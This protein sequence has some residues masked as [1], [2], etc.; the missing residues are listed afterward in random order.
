MSRAVNPF[1]SQTSASAPLQWPLNKSSPPS[2]RSIM[3][4]CQTL[5]ILQVQPGPILKNEPENSFPA[6]VL[7]YLRSGLLCRH[8]WREFRCLVPWQV[9]PL[10]Q[11]R[12]LKLSAAVSCTPSSSSACPRLLLVSKYSCGMTRKVWT[13]VI[14]CYVIVCEALGD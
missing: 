6:K 13:N 2:H 11:L 4:C 5:L 7:L 3:Q 8:C 9:V 10:L 14:A 12:L 1:L